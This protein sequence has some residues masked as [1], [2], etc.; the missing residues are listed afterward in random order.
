MTSP[1]SPS[2]RRRRR[3]VVAIAVLLVGLAWWY[4]PRV[5]QRF[6]GKW[7]GSGVSIDLRADGTCLW[8]G[9]EG[10]PVK[11]KWSVRNRSLNL[12]NAHLQPLSELW[13]RIHVALHQTTG[14]PRSMPLGLV[15]DMLITKFDGDMMQLD[16]GLDLK[17]VTESAKP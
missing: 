17:R 6:V 15:S 8:S 13:I 16:H 14:W 1:P 4:W 10:S 9:F 12:W 7:S 11:L 2:G 3:I 5:D